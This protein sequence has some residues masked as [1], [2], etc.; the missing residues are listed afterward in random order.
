MT[1]E[2]IQDAAPSRTEP[3]AGNA[4]GGASP[5]E[6]SAPAVS[7]PAVEP[8]TAAAEVGNAAS[9]VAEQ[10]T[11]EPASAPAAPVAAG[12]S[13]T[14]ANSPAEPETFE[15]RVEA[16]F[17]ALEGYLMKL[18]HS[19]AHAFSISSMATTDAEEI[20]KRAL[21]HLFGKN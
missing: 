12:V 10:S 14:V 20:G 11:A 2:V 17:L 16:R 15:Q 6:T 7:A 4:A 1:D 19:I 3:V 13:P 5:V 8:S 21:A 18:P 9:P